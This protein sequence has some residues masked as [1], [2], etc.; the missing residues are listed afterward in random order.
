[1]EELHR[2]TLDEREAPRSDAAARAQWGHA[3]LLNMSSVI[4][5]INFLSPFSFLHPDIFISD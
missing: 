2:E 5:K 3:Q 4:K 1:M